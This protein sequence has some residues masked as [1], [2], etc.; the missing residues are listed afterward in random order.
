[1][2]VSAGLVMYRKR[3]SGI[4]VLLV[5]PGGPFW[6]NKDLGAW[7]IP[8]GEVEAGEELLDVARREFLE[9]T[10]HE[11]E[12]PFL[13]LGAVRQKAGKTVH[14]WAFEGDCDPDALRSNDVLIEWPPRS[15]KKQR[16][17]EVDRAEFFELGLAKTKINPAQAALLDE[18]A[19]RLI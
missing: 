9:E 16:F 4:E 18:L 3:P 11:P 19:R 2:R 5:H 6:R 12:G 7:S 17:P 1:M 10:G 8:K 15:G 13:E 14:A